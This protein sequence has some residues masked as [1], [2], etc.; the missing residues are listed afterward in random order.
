MMQGSNKPKNI[1]KPTGGPPLEAMTAENLAPPTGMEGREEDL[2]KGMQSLVKTMKIKIP[3]PHDT[4]DAL[5]KAH[6]NAIQFAK[7]NGLLQAYVEHDY[8]TMKPLLDRTKAMIE[9]TGNKELALVMNFERTGCFFQM[10]LDAHAEPGKRSFT[11]PFRKVLNA[12]KG[13]GQFDLTEE[14][15]LDQWWRP[16]YLGYGKAIGVEFKISDMDQNGKV[17]VELAE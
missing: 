6:L 15:I 16:R 17:T 13:L 8:K 4:N 1:G 14:E 10:F 2:A 5:L 11:F 3:Y 9:A 7:D 12:A